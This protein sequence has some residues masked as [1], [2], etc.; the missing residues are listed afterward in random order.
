MI[1][2]ARSLARR[3]RRAAPLVAALALALSL[4]GCDRCGD[5]FWQRQPGTCHGAP[6]PN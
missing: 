5:F 2:Q 3:C 4:A 6:A 1:E